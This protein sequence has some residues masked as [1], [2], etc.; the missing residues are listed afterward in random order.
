MCGG[1][2]FPVTVELTSPSEDTSLLLQ[3]GSHSV[4]GG[5]LGDAGILTP[6]LL[7]QSG[8]ASKYALSI[9]SST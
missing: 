5:R 1:S 7:T 8:S 6:T 3:Q 4:H 2:Y 9:L